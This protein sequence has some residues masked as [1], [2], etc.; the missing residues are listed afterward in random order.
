MV[1]AQPSTFN[2][3]VEKEKN[4]LALE[5]NEVREISELLFKRLEKK[6]QAVEKLE[7]A[8]E[9][10]TGALEKK[11]QAFETISLKKRRASQ[12]PCSATRA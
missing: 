12:A 8:V 10:K 9:R 6:V 7:A 5:L 11:M 1:K 3:L 4:L 2:A